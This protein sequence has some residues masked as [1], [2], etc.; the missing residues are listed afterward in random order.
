ML[1][2]LIISTIALSCFI[3][4]TEIQCQLWNCE[5][6]D[7][8]GYSVDNLKMRLDAD[9]H[10]HVLYYDESSSIIK[11]AFSDGSI[12]SVE[13]I[14][15]DYEYDNFDLDSFNNIHLVST[16]H[17]TSYRDLIYAYIDS[18]GIFVDTIFSVIGRVMHADIEVDQNDFP[19]ISANFSD[20]SGK[21]ILYCYKDDYGW[22][23]ETVSPLD[24]YLGT[25]DIELLDNG[26]VAILSSNLDSP[27]YVTYCLKYLNTW[28]TEIAYYY[29]GSVYGNY[30]SLAFDTNNNPHAT[31]YVNRVRVR[32]S[33]D[34]INFNGSEWYLTDSLDS[35]YDVRSIVPLRFSSQNIAS[36]A[37]SSI[38]S[39]TRGCYYA[40]MDQADS[41]W[42]YY[43]VESGN[44]STPVDI[45]LDTNDNIHVV[46]MRDWFL[47]YAYHGPFSSINNYDDKGFEE[48]DHINIFPNPTNSSINFYVN[49][50]SGSMPV[51]IYLYD[52]LGRKVYQRNSYNLKEGENCLNLSFDDSHIIK[53]ASG[54]YFL[55]IVGHDLD[56]NAKFTL[57]K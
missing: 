28:S 49:N 44:T 27:G 56:M 46:Y 22:H 45:R 8:L 12:W 55:R 26:D 51:D 9:Q 3:G 47:I 38:D 15:L 19:H 39:L 34:V 11:H 50:V 21:Y 29:T 53:G 36:I 48:Q 32:G 14:A 10:P 42:N 41:T 4:T 40:Y 17:S 43:L 1:K 31:I 23:N 37:F 57:I 16:Q 6:I 52:L 25:T 18:Q 30:I 7:S 35:S 13:D 24:P 20:Q 2:T 5:H 54:Q 33:V